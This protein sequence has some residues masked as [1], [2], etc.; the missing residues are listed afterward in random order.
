MVF[1]RRSYKRLYLNISASQSQEPFVFIRTRISESNCN[2]LFADSDVFAV[3]AK[4]SVAPFKVSATSCSKTASSP[5]TLDAEITSNAAK[6]TCLRV[7]Q[8]ITG[9]VR[10]FKTCLIPIS[11]AFCA[12][13]AMLEGIVFMSADV[14]GV[15]CARTYCRNGLWRRKST[16]S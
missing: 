14:G 15:S 2:A 3:L 11:S 8:L 12:R 10:T 1:T 6:R 13:E 7:N 16:D 4:I 9:N 5:I